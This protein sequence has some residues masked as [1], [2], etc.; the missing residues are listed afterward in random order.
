M[1]TRMMKSAKVVTAAAALSLALAAASPAQ[2]KMIGASDNDA[3]GIATTAVIGCGV[4]MAGSVLAT[5]FTAGFGAV[6]FAGAAKACGI[7]AAVGASAG[8]IADTRN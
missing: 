6:T 4:A 7:A 1:A 2:A 3:V 8:T 5:I